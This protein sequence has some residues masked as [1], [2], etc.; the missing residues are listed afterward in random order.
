MP[1]ALMMQVTSL[2][3][4]TYCLRP[5]RTPALRERLRPR[6]SMAAAWARVRRPLL[7]NFGLDVG[8]PLSLYLQPPFWVGV[9]LFRDLRDCLLLLRLRDLLRDFDRAMSVQ[10]EYLLLVM[11]YLFMGNRPRTRRDAVV[12]HW[13]H[14][15][16]FFF[17]SAR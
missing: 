2:A 5:W 13:A 8:R 14:A 11:Y 7:I 1:L 6:F 17:F 12:W 9:Q 15:I 10:A 3:L 16:L 4:P